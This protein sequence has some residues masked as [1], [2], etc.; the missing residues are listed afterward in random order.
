MNRKELDPA[1]FVQYADFYD[2]NACFKNITGGG[3]PGFG[4]V[5]A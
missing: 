2:T 4:G 5:I 1:N 3:R